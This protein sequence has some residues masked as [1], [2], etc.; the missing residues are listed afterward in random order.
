MRAMMQPV[1]TMEI[2]SMTMFWNRLK[3]GDQSR[4]SSSMKIAQQMATTSV[5]TI[6]MNGLS[7]FVVIIT[8][9]I[10]LVIYL[11]PCLQLNRIILK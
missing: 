3:F 6:G 10:V 9:F 4:A 5:A 1:M 11:F 8:D 2:M 7:S